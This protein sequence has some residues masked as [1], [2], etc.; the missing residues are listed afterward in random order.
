MKTKINTVKLPSGLDKKASIISRREI[1]PL[2]DKARIILRYYSEAV[3][4]SAAVLDRN[5][6]C[7]RTP[8]YKKQIRFCG[9]CK[10]HYR[11]AS[12]NPETPEP[13]QKRGE[14]EHPCKNIHFDAQAESLRRGEAYIY[15]CPIGF[16]YWTSPLYRKGHYAGNLVS[17]QVLPYGYRDTVENFR[18]V[19]GDGIAVEKFAEMIKEAPVKN[20]EEI[21]AMARLLGICAEEISEKGENHD[22]MIVG[23]SWQK[24]S[25]ETQNDRKKNYPK[26]RDGQAKEAGPEYPLEKER[27]LLAAFRRGDTDTGNRIMK[28]LMENILAVVPENFEIVRFR[29]IELVVL[30]SRAA[31]SRVTDCGA[32]LETNNRYLKRIQESGTPE[33]LIENLRLIAESMSGKI[34]SFQGIRHASVLRKAERYI[35][36]NYNRKISLEEVAG[37]A[38]LS[39]P[40]FSTIFKEEMGE[41]LSGYINRLR[42]DK[43]T[44][45]LIETSMPLNEIAELCGF[46][47]QSWFS[48][49]FKIYTGM[50][51]G[52]Y[53]ENSSGLREFRPERNHAEGDILFPGEAVTAQ[54]EDQILSS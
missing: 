22:E 36:E 43:A 17:G 38:G 35:W 48:K 16:I 50:S 28:E 2:L 41:N 21:Q 18:A 42:I 52:K 9:F 19:C 3:D 37:A 54:S 23:L 47:D 12:H 49:I 39:A 24:A 1:E 4:C 51:P 31:V 11:K 25:A 53:R 15:T 13:A 20:H 10:K 46:E 6:N 27:M 45:M 14:Y 34:F 29:A 7:M 5:G 40:Y 32:L 26:N 33:E 30:L 8:E 44:T